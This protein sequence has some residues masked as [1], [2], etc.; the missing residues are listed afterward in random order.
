MLKV[1]LLSLSSQYTVDGQYI[2]SL[3]IEPEV[4]HD[5]TSYNERKIWGKHFAS[6]QDLF[7]NLY[8]MYQ[9]FR[10][11]HCLEILFFALTWR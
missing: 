6:Y 11:G 4:R 8:K 3:F 9:L 5:K 10:I 7:S 1:L 2:P